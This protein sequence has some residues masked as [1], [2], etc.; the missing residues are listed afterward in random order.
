MTTHAEPTEQ[1]RPEH[2]H[3]D[4]HGHGHGHDPR[5]GADHDHDPGLLAELLDLDAALLPDA[6]DD[7][8]TWAVAA[9]G[10]AR[11]RRVLDVGAGTGTG[12]VALARLLPC[13]EV[14]ALDRSPAMLRRVEEAA[15]A[16]G[17]A[18]RVR[19]VV[20]DLD[21]PLPA[22]LADGGPV[23]LVWASAS[24]HEVADPR[25]VL[26]RLRDLLAPEGV[27]VAVE[28][29]AP[30]SVLPDAGDVAGL[31]ARVHAAVAALHPDHD[32]NPDWGDV[33]PEV[34]LDV[35]A[36]RTVDVAPAAAPDQTLLARYGRLFLGMRRERVAPLLDPAD[37]ALLDALL[38]DGPASFERRGD[39]V[40]AG[41]RTAWA[42]RRRG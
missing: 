12:T 36:R 30:P 5:P 27:L 23:D 28:M 7:L 11:V 42:A 16:A 34:G 8:A 13:A 26:A 31:E 33:L 19:T 35:V 6:L 10:D 20:A 15:R 1:H 29:D 40:L 24:L 22:A 4:G 17:V 14:V 37:R 38:G 25:G 9:R 2:P 21:E 39:L 3:H 32:L 18:D 41:A